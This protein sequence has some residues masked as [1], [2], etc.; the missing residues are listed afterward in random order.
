MKL[1]DASVRAEGVL[2]LT[3]VTPR[4][5]EQRIIDD[6]SWLITHGARLVATEQYAPSLNPDASDD[7]VKEYTEWVKTLRSIRE[8]VENLITGILP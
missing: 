7:T 4:E 2:D 5:R 3:D 1:K 6:L 8:Q